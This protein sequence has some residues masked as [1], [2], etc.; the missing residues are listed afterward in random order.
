MKQTGKVS[1]LNI[2]HTKRTLFTT[3]MFT[4]FNKNSYYNNMCYDIFITYSWHHTRFWD[5][6]GV[7]LHEIK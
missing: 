3:I 6:E 4:N 5:K 7:V 2:M 1:V